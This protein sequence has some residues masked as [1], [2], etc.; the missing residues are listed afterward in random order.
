MLGGAVVSNTYVLVCMD[1]RVT[2]RVRRR[3]DPRQIRRLDTWP[4]P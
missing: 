4:L 1:F 3:W 2:P